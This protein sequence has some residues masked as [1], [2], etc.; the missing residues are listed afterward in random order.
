MVKKESKQENN[1]FSL[2]AIIGIVFLVVFIVL[3]VL[4]ISLIFVAGSFSGDSYSSGNVAL[5]KV[6]GVIMTQSQSDIFGQSNGVSSTRMVEIID[7][8]AADDS[9]KAIMIEINSPGGSGVASDEITTALRQSGKPVVSYIREVGAS[10]AYWIASASD[11]IYANKFSTVGSIGVIASY[12]DFSGLIA[13]YNVTYQRFVAGENKD[14]GTPF[15]QVTPE[16]DENFQEQLDI[17]HQAFIQEVAIG[18]SMSVEQITVLADGSI[19][20]GIQSVQN[21]LIDEIGGKKEATDYLKTTL[22]LDNVQLI[23][24]ID[25][26]SFFDLLGGYIAQHGFSIG[27]GVVSK[28][29]VE[30]SFSIKT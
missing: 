29:L 22:E 27:K 10:G 21:G 25:Q 16:Q 14:F 28:P 23:E 6:D 12:L 18:R 3:P 24:Y 13:D 20:T 1:S 5:L 7:S 8:I 11:R 15:R 19:Y 26:V 2:I 9:I 4:F 17:L 30:N